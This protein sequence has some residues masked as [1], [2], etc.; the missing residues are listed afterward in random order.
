MLPDLRV[1]ASMIILS[2]VRSGIS[3]ATQQFKRR[4]YTQYCYARENRLEY[5]SIVTGLLST[6]FC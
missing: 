4:A 3:L 5:V 6:D 1:I 2:H